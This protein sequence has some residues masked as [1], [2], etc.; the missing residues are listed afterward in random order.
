MGC[1]RHKIQQWVGMPAQDSSTVIQQSCAP[2][3]A[4]TKT[5]S[6]PE[7]QEGGIQPYRHRVVLGTSKDLCSH[8]Q[9][10]ASDLPAVMWIHSLPSKSRSVPTAVTGCCS[11]AKGSLLSHIPHRG[12]ARF[13]VSQNSQLPC[14]PR[15]L[16]TLSMH[17]DGCENIH[18]LPGHPNTKLLS[19]LLLWVLDTSVQHTMEKFQSPSLP[20]WAVGLP[21]CLIVLRKGDNQGIVLA[22]ISHCSG[23]LGE[24]GP[25]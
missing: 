15:H 12:F 5:T 19:C 6:C 13:L 22:S 4:G 10:A 18:V 20:F 1:R 25:L 16:Y 17:C 3:S 7:N 2:Q 11:K 23:A 8:W 9:G 14:Y 21:Q 24:L